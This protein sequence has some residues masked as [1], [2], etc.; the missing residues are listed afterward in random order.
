MVLIGG[1]ELFKLPLMPG[2]QA[3]WSVPIP[4]DPSFA[5]VTIYTQAIHVLGVSPFA[6]SNA[7]DLFL[8]Y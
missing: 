7:Q 8:A 1:P 4:S 5:C 2:P 6:L 3:M